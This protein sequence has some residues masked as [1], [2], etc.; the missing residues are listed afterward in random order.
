VKRACASGREIHFD[1]AVSNRIGPE[2]SHSRWSRKIAAPVVTS[3]ASAVPSGAWSRQRTR[4]CG[5]IEGGTRSVTPVTPGV[6]GSVRSARD[7]DRGG[8]TRRRYITPG[9]SQ[10]WK[11]P[12]AP[13]HVPHS[14]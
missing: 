9:M 8:L 5:V 7:H 3:P 11:L 6:I 14:P 4:A 2:Q 10:S 12:S 13:R 1:S